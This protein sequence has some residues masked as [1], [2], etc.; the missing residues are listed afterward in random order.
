MGQTPSTTARRD[1]ASTRTLHSSSL[2]SSG[3]N[4]RPM[5]FFRRISRRLHAH[6]NR[7]FGRQR[8]TPTSI[9]PSMTSSVRRATIAATN[10]AAVATGPVPP[11]PF[12]HIDPHP[13]NSSSASTTSAISNASDISQIISDIVSSAVLSSLSNGQLDA[14]N[15]NTN[16]NGNG[17]QSHDNTSFF[18]YMHMPIRS[19]HQT[20]NEDH[21][22]SSNNAFLPIFIVGYRTNTTD[23]PITPTSNNNF[24][25]NNNNS[26]NNNNINNNN[27]NSTPT[28]HPPPPPI[29]TSIHAN[30][31]L[32][33]PHSAISTSSS[34]A[35]LQSMPLSIQSSRT[36]HTNHTNH[37]THTSNPTHIQQQHHT[38]T[39]SLSIH[40]N[41]V[42]NNNNTHTTTNAT[43]ATTTTNN[44]NSNNNNNNNPTHQR[45]SLA[46]SSSSSSSASS[47]ASTTTGGGRWV[48]YVISGHHHGNNNSHIQHP[49][50][51]RL[52]ENPSYEDLLWLSNILGP[53]RPV[54]TTQQAID[55][56]LPIHSWSDET[57]K[58]AMLQD[59]EKCLVCLDDFIPKQSVRILKCRHVFHVECV[60]RW[61]VESHN[62]CPICR[63][64]P[65][66][67]TTT[68]NSA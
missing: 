50:L 25:N 27:I 35:T 53:A 29:P 67:T 5:S 60:D 32:R 49:A 39:A 55:A 7:R 17:F 38:S 48:I 62:S 26:N 30:S 9:A 56:S 51:A 23:N 24:I 40:N 12:L 42:Y 34:L 57:T 59:T 28:S 46:S 6:P 2:H 52:S 36:N 47:S 45:E 66:A 8:A 13:S 41:N 22:Q 61:L 16:S 3:N 19:Q 1:N 33:R 44:N 11:L 18:R 10:A 58:K 63:F 54:T 15:N 21:N 43:T 37:T 20:S 14:N 64:V 65:V 68:T 4:N 31:H